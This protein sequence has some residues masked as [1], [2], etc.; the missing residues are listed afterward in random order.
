MTARSLDGTEWLAVQVRAGRERSSADHLRQR[1]IDVFLPFYREPRQWSDRVKQLERALFAGYVFCRPHGAALRTILVAPGVIRIVG[2]GQGPLAV[3]AAEIGA[4]QQ[5]I[6]ACL[7]AAPWEF[8][9]IGQRV[10]VESGPLR[11]ADGIVLLIKGNRR[12]VLSIPLLQRSVAV[13][14]HADWLTVPLP[15]A[16]PSLPERAAGSGAG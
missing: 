5:I 15:I 1:D 13:E 2:D 10:R 3:P 6:D 16:S 7:L 8:V 11:G 4:I 14:M 12:L 9:Q